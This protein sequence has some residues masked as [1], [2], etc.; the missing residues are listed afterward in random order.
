MTIM[1]TAKTTLKKAWHSWQSATTP[2]LVVN[3][4][5]VNCPRSELGD[6][7]VDRC[8]SCLALRTIDVEDDGTE[9]IRCRPLPSAS[10]VLHEGR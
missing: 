9:V 6:V 1:V 5:R 3:G 4:G 10:Y 7:D 8:Y 2:G